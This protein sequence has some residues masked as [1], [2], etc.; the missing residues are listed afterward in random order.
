M[1]MALFKPFII[2]S[3]SGCVATCVIQP[4]DTIKVVIQSRRE[5]AGKTKINLSPFHVGKQLIDKNGFLSLYRGLDSALLRQVVYTGIRLGLYRVFEDD[6]KYR[7]K[8]FMT[9]GE[10]VG[11][12][13]LA[14]LIG[15]AIANPLDMSLIRFQADSNLP[16]AEKRNYKHVGDALVQMKRELG[17]FGMWRGS[18]PTITRA[19][20]LNSFTLVAYNE[21]KEKLQ[22]WMGET[23]ETT[24]I[25][26]IGSAI[27]GVSASIGSL[28][29]DNMKVK[30]LKMKPS[31]LYF[32]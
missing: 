3:I 30:I 7:Q 6:I 27:S 20:A 2:G 24:A 8:R 23:K 28:P 9:F 12:S 32:M 31:K 29:F 11:Y 16:A 1:F 4:I 21:A 18:I 5:A 19:M 13:M 15:S 14:G 10:K 17:F 26:L 22:K 25:R